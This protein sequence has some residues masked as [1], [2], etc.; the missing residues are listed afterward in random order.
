MLSVIGIEESIFYA[1]LYI[2]RH[3]MHEGKFLFTILMMFLIMLQ[4]R[5]NR[6]Q[7]IVISSCPETSPAREAVQASSSSLVLRSLFWTMKSQQA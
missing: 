7:P 2:K 1:H 5:K 4:H 6:K 3:V